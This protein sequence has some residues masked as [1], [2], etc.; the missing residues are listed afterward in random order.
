MTKLQVHVRYVG[1][2][3]LQHFRPSQNCPRFTWGKGSAVVRQHS[4]LS[5][6]LLWRLTNRSLPQAFQLWKRCN[7]CA[8]LRPWQTA[9][10]HSA[11]IY[12]L[13]TS[14]Q[15]GLGNA[16]PNCFCGFLAIGQ[17]LRSKLATRWMDITPD[18]NKG[19]L[20][21]LSHGMVLFA[22]YCPMKSSGPFYPE[23]ADK[24]VYLL[25]LY[26]RTVLIFHIHTYIQYVSPETAF[27]YFSNTLKIV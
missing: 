10:P 5:S 24:I 23:T 13:H 19:Y 26:S 22:Y 18:Q 21:I 11:M 9:D 14:S 3:P 8:L 7:L 4:A 15:T 17:R 1:T 6:T 25:N 27:S 2:A 12:I 16:R 20:V